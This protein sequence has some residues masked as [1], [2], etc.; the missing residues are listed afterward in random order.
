MAMFR[1][2]VSFGLL[3]GAQQALALVIG[4]YELSPHMVVDGQKEPAGAVV[5][6]ARELVAKAPDC[7]P[8]TWRPTSFARSLRELET[9][10]VDMVFMVARNEQRSKVF[11]YGSL[12]LFE[13][14]SALVVPKGSSLANLTSL[15]QVRGLQIGH[16]NASIIPEYLRA[17]NV[18]VHPISGDDYFFRGLKMLES[19]RIDAYFAPTL[20]NAQYQ[21]RKYENADALTVQPLPVE[22]L[23]LYVVFSKTLDEK[24]YA[25]LDALI[26]ANQARYKLLLGNYLR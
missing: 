6:F 14:R 18:V 21:M 19:K 7:G 20:S 25:K 9:G 24:T 12:P 2:L 4:V 13:T 23:A 15:E 10:E 22:P 17:L 3:L 1:F 16:A 5:D 11:R 26:S 8:L